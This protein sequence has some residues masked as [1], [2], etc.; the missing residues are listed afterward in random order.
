MNTKKI[1]ILLTLLVTVL[2]SACNADQEGEIYSGSG[3]NDLSFSAS[4]LGSF[5]LAPSAPTLQVDLFR[6]N[7]SG[8]LTGQVNAAV[9]VGNEAYDNL[10]SVSD[11][12][13]ADGVGQTS[14]VLDATNLPIGVTA[15]VALSLGNAD[16]VSI[17]GNASTSLSIAIDYTWQS[18]GMGTWQDGLIS[19]LFQVDDL[20]ITWEVEVQQAGENPS[21]YRVVDAYGFG[22]C[23]YVLESEVQAGGPFYIQIDTTNP[24]NVLVPQSSMGIDW[25]YG[26]FQ[27]GSMYY[28]DGASAGGV[29]SGNVINLGTSLFCAMGADAYLTS[30]PTILTLPE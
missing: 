30:Q 27:T 9:T 11:Y 13:F 26:L 6:G 19:S 1:F 12:T 21:L 22:I 17:G 29:M 2:F 15:N 10:I 16:D 25:G 14:I 18:L 3:A 20:T 8:Q 4:N 28:L 23:P 7:I 5:T 24:N